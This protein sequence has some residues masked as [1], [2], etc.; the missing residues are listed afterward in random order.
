MAKCKFK[1]GDRVKATKDNSNLITGNAMEVGTVTYVGRS[2]LFNGD[3]RL[4]VLKHKSKK[5]EGI[6]FLSNHVSMKKLVK[7]PLLFTAKATK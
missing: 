2:G 7:K 6:E 4:K 3:M 1:I 5:F